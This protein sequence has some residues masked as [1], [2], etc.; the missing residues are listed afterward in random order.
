MSLLNLHIHAFSDSEWNDKI[1][2]ALA[3]AGAELKSFAGS[4]TDKLV[5]A[6]K[7]N[8]PDLVADIKKGIADVTDPDTKGILKLEAV[9]VDV[10]KTVPD[11]LAALPHLKDF[12]I[13]LVQSVYTDGL[14]ELESVAASFI[15]K[16][17]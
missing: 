1:K 3:D 10:A 2:P 11:A 9:A 6:A 5:I 16:I 14:S 15:A 12:M 13:Q 17:L 4:E 7:A 8:F